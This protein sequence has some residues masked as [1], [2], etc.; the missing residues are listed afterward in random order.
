M[1]EL[2]A[3]LDA[4]QRRSR[5]AGAET[6]KVQKQLQDL[7]A[8]AEEDHRTAV[9]LTETVNTLQIRIVTLKRQLEES[10]SSYSVHIHNF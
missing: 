1:R 7:R 5:D 6:R 9:E 4:E 8:Q 2:E 10:V 3:D